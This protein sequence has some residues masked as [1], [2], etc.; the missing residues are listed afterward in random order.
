MIFKVISPMEGCL[1]LK[2]SHFF[3]LKLS[4][5]YKRG[6]LPVFDLLN[7]IQPFCLLQLCNEVF[8]INKKIRT[9]RTYIP[10]RF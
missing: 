9:K 2:E 6:L 10:S 1:Y 8:K 3:W 4:C 5:W 7:N